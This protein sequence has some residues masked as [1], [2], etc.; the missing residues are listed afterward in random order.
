MTL[1]PIA[2][3]PGLPAA[4]PDQGLARAGRLPSEQSPRIGESGAKDGES[5]SFGEILRGMLR[6]EGAAQHA[7]EEYA[8]GKSQ[9]LHE[10]MI[11][12][13]KA[14]INFSLLVSVRNKLLDAYREVM[15]MS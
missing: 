9:N 3:T 7:A 10:T 11:A 12:L 13:E 6:T 15:R 2:P 14:D 8:T 4:L 5:L 1:S